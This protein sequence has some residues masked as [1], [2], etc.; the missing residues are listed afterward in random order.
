MA[1]LWSEP[2]YIPKKRFFDGWLDMLRPDNQLH[3]EVEKLVQNKTDNGISVIELDNGSS[4]KVDM[5]NVPIE[6]HSKLVKVTKLLNE[7]RK[8]KSTEDKYL[9]Y[10]DSGAYVSLI[11]NKKDGNNKEII[12]VLER[13]NKQYSTDNSSC[14]DYW[15][16]E[17]K[18]F[19]PGKWIVY[20]ENLIQKI[21]Q[22]KIDTERKRFEEQWLPIDDEFIFAQENLVDKKE[23]KKDN[24]FLEI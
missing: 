12:V 5:R 24:N 16:W 6:L 3:P 15:Y 10:S 19:R 9:A 4:I 14:P 8:I 13:N 21:K 22:D 18:K 20:L 23:E 2:D 7:Y 17:I 1:E 11:I